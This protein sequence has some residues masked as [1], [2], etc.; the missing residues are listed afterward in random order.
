MASTAGRTMLKL[1]A[2][3]AVLLGSFWLTLEILDYWATPQ[4]PN[5]DLIAGDG[6][7]LWHELPGGLWQGAGR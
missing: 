3:A 1:T 6:S 5:A 2:A 7:D 4:D